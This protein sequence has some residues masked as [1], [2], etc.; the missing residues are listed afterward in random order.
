[1]RSQ[2][3]P[4]RAVDLRLEVR[5][6][7]ELVLGHELEPLAVQERARG[8]LV[9]AGQHLH[10]VL[11]EPVPVGG[12]GD[13]DEPFAGERGDLV[14]DLRLAGA[15]HDADRR[16]VRE[17]AEH[18]LDRAVERRLAVEARAVL[19]EQRAVA[20]VAG[21]ARAVGALHERDQLR[22]RRRTPRRGTA[23]SASRGASGM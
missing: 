16:R 18:V 2:I 6:Q 10:A 1:M 3:A 5:V 13:D 9:V 20:G 11:V 19:D 17:V 7:D 23:A 15:H 8:D 22:R 21:E 4:S 12:L 14:R